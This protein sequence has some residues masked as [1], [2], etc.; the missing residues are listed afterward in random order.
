M[1]SCR[2]LAVDPVHWLS[3]HVIKD[4][5][6]SLLWQI[7]VYLKFLLEEALWPERNWVTILTFS[8]PSIVEKHHFF[9]SSPQNHCAQEIGSWSSFP[10]F[11]FKL[12]KRTYE[13]ASHLVVYH[14][15]HTY[16]QPFVFSLSFPSS[17]L[18]VSAGS[19]SET[20]NLGNTNW[21]HNI[22]A[23]LALLHTIPMRFSDF[24]HFFSQQLCHLPG[25]HMINVMCLM[26]SDFVKAFLLKSIRSINQAHI[27]QTE[28]KRKA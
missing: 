17:W 21:H 22:L 11:S 9:T 14:H 25:W 5:T 27:T 16:L 15:L 12:F 2:L 28:K 19:H 20:V 18:H 6:L 10:S 13:S 26:Y 1:L 23:N 4:F 24:S 7:L 8:H 3:F